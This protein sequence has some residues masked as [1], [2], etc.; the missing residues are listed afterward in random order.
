MSDGDF[1]K[2]G[3]LRQIIGWIIL[4]D[5]NRKYRKFLTTGKRKTIIETRK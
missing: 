5:I 1:E 2:L 4:N 3:R